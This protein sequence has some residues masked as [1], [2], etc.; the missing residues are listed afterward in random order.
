MPRKPDPVNPSASPW[1]LLGAELRHQRDQV[2]GLTLRQAAKL[3]LCD[4]ADL[5]KWERGLAHPQPDTVRRLDD[6][7]G[8]NGRLAA[9]H[10]FVAELDKLR[11]LAIKDPNNEENV[12]ERRQL[13]QLAAAGA[14]FSALN[15]AAEPLRQLLQMDL[16]E[17]HTIEDWQLACADHLN[18]IHTRPPAQARDDLHID[19]LELQRQLRNASDANEIIDLRRVVAALSTLYANLLSRLGEHG[20]ALR[21]WHT[22]R[23]A[24]DATGDLHLRLGVQ[25]T[26]AGHILGHGQRTP[27][28]VLRLTDQAQQIAGDAR[29]LGT[30]FVLCSR[31]KALSLVGRHAEAQATVNK[32]R[33]IMASE[34]PAASIMPEVWR[35]R[36][37]QLEY[38]ELW[39]NAGT[40]N[41]KATADAC[42][43]V[44]SVVKD[45]QYRT[46]A[47]LQSALCTVVSG[48]VDEGLQHAAS[49]IDAL[50]PHYRTNQID[51]IGRRILHSVP[52]DKRTHSAAGDLQALLS[53]RS[54]R[55]AVVPGTRPS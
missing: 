6:V 31:A 3:A 7:Y 2:R 25:A 24:A 48:G 39:V 11:T 43:R 27:L 34:P 14:G 33:D 49:T 41:E 18:A 50:P 55:E 52:A 42:E 15:P 30:A 10:A 28:T 40:G 44:L 54:F 20:A 47:R 21:W 46:M 1:H 29:S 51:Q 17:G 36:G 8:T 26:A 5:S 9:L 4:D 32:C 13:L 45:Y 35:M 22:A 16:G 38:T 23:T 19:L 37:G 12:T 53:R